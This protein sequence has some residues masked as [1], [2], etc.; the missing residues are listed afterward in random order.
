LRG[1]LIFWFAEF[2][3]YNVRYNCISTE[4]SLCRDK[5][6]TRENYVF[7]VLLRISRTERR[8]SFHSC[9]SKTAYGISHSQLYG[10]VWCFLHAFLT[11]PKGLPLFHNDSFK[12][13]WLCDFQCK[14]AFTRV[15]PG[16][17]TRLNQRRWIQ[18]LNDTVYTVPQKW[19]RQSISKWRQMN[20]CGKVLESSWQNW[21]AKL[22]AL[23]HSITTRYTL[24]NRSWLAACYA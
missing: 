11:W 6:D 19:T 2:T 5:C 12:L 15:P 23:T 8:M 4:E 9:T 24:G 13:L 14:G 7:A 1:N 3:F 20:S 16:W 21:E 10:P 18:R 22:K 17:S